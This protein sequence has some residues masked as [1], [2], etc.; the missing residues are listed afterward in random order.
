MN[1]LLR[2]SS[3]HVSYY[4]IVFLLVF[5]PLDFSRLLHPSPLILERLSLAY[6]VIP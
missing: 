4:L 2:P 3:Y 5:I 1:I 6:L